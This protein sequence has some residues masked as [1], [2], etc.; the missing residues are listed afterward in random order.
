MRISRELNAQG[1][2]TG[3]KLRVGSKSSS[4][5]A[6][7]GVEGKATDNFARE[8]YSQYVSAKK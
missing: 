6:L 5:P 2:R 8:A 1:Q 3:Q 4:S 7:S